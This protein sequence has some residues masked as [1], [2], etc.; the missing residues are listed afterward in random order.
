MTIVVGHPTRTHD[1]A[2]ISLGAMLGRSLGTDLLVVSVVP[3]PWPTLVAGNVDKEYAAWS[4]EA[5]AKA[6][7]DAERVLGEVAADL[8][9]RAVAVPGRSVPVALLEQARLVDAGLVVV[10]SAEDGDWDRVALGSTADHLLHT[11]HVPVAVAPKGF[12]T[13][14]VPR[15]GRATCAFRAD[16][17]SQDVLRRTT[18][19]CT[20]AGAAVRIATFGVLGKTMYPPEVRG[21]QDVL[22]SF[23]EQAERALATAAAATGLR[24]VD[25]VVATGRDWAQAVSRLE[26]RHDDVLVLGSSP[27]GMLARVFVGSHASRI[28]RHSPVPVVVVPET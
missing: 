2:A 22:D 1:R 4:R 20:E 10:G 26:W 27:R 23:V 16:R 21:E 12:A 5:G 17:S 8:D 7:A 24:E 25:H 3:A 19:I 14:A 9:T 15:F 11:A 6:V 13:H 18:E 28:I